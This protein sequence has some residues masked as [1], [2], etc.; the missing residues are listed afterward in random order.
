VN[1]LGVIDTLGGYKISR[2]EIS[3]NFASE[4][5][6]VFREIFILFREISPKFRNR[7]SRNKLENFAK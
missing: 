5:T 6:F 1:N 3:Q 2:Y 4:I 7:I